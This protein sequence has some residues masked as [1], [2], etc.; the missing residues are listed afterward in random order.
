[1]D[2]CLILNISIPLKENV[3]F[4]L[5]GF[6]LIAF[7]V[8]VFY[9]IYLVIRARMWEYKILP[10]GQNTQKEYFRNAYICS[11]ILLLDADR[12][13]AKS[14]QILVL[15]KL[16]SLGYAKEWILGIWEQLIEQQVSQK[17]VTSWIRFNLTAPERQELMFLMVE[18]AYTDGFL[19][20]K[21]LAIFRDFAARLDISM[22]DVSRM[23][24][25]HKQ[26]THRQKAERDQKERTYKK[27]YL[28]PT[29]TE[30]ELAFE[31]LG[32]SSNASQAEIKKAY[33]SLVKKH[34][35]DRFAGK[36]AIIIE[37]AKAQFIEIQQAYELI[38]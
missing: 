31:I 25:S 38:Q 8:P 4:G 20:S 34:H 29:K 1:M 26:R 15:N 35:P 13:D 5:I 12:R 19:V 36:D 27:A 14:K 2:L 30:R 18:L 7:G 33:R 16:Q 17:H 28:K 24:A 11:A 3:G 23:M 9:F 6:L 21:E 10:K 22:K 32:V 37:A